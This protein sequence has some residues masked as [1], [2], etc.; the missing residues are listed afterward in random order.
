MFSIDHS[1]IIKDVHYDIKVISL[2]CNF[3]VISKIVYVNIKHRFKKQGYINYEI[4]IFHSYIISTFLLPHIK[5]NCR[6][7][8]C[9]FS[10]LYTKAL[11]RQIHSTGS[12]F[13]W[14]LLVLNKLCIVSWCILWYYVPLRVM[15]RILHVTS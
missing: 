14:L 5:W 2:Y 13:H 11:I 1:L 12:D 3:L 10:I 15:N 9:Q 8:I 4:Y 6:D 7:V